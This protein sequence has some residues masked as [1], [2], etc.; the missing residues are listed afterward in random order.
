MRWTSRQHLEMARHLDQKAKLATGTKKARL[1]GLAAAARVLATT[2]VERR[3][4]NPAEAGQFDVEVYRQAFPK[5]NAAVASLPGD[6]VDTLTVVR[7]LVKHLAGIGLDADEI[8]HLKPYA[9]QF[10]NDLIACRRPSMQ[11]AA[12]KYW[13]EI[14]ESQLLRT[15]WAQ[16]MFPLP[17]EDMDLAMENEEKRLIRETSNPV[18]ASAYLKI[19]PLL[20]ESAAISSYLKENPSLRAAIPPIESIAEATMIAS[21]DFRLA[22]R[23]LVQLAEMLKD[24]PRPNGALSLANSIIDNYKASARKPVRHRIEASWIAEAL[25]RPSFDSETMVRVT[26]DSSSTIMELTS[27]ESFVG[28]PFTHKTVV[29]P[30]CALQFWT[31]LDAMLAT[32][33]HIERNIGFDGITIE[34]DCRTPAG[35]AIFDTWS[36]ASSTQVG[37]LVGLIYDLTRETSSAASAIECLKRL[38]GYLRH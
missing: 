8:R 30:S 38:H 36:P 32:P 13:N 35:S 25:F 2:Y 24:P 33:L 10:I 5:F 17:Q 20:W 14:A 34:V 4:S 16:Q 12:A 15:E 1:A 29:A 7:A 37:R 28:P 21:M 6:C 26:A 31:K 18:L 23:E 3:S 19:M 22:K 27:A 11:Q 9:K